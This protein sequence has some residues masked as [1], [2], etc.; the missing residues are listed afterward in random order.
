MEVVTQFYKYSDVVIDSDDGSVDD[1]QVLFELLDPERHTGWGVE[2]VP[3]SPHL[4]LTHRWIGD[5]RFLPINPEEKIVS[6]DHEEKYV[7]VAIESTSI[8]VYSYTVLMDCTSHPFTI[9][10]FVNS[11]ENTLFESMK[12]EIENE[13]DPLKKWTNKDGNP[14]RAKALATRLQALLHSIDLQVIRNSNRELLMRGSEVSR[15]TISR[16]ESPGSIRQ[17]TPT[18][19]RAS[20]AKPRQSKTAPTQQPKRQR[21]SGAPES[22][23]RKDKM[24]EKPNEPELSIASALT[25]IPKELKSGEVPDYTSATDI[26]EKYWSDCQDCYIFDKSVKKE[27]AISQLTPAPEDWTIRAFEQ[28]GMRHMMNYLI[29]MPDKT[30]KQTLCVMPA[31]ESD[32]VTKDDW[33][34]I[35]RGKFWIING[36]HSVA[37]SKEMLISNPPIPEQILKHF[38]TW[39]CYIIFTRDKEKLRKISAFYNRVNHFA[40]FMPSWSTN[41]LGARTIWINLGRPAVAAKPSST[42]TQLTKAEKCY[43]VRTPTLSSRILCSIQ[44]DSS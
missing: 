31:V 11:V 27:L 12:K 17:Q 16:S 43:N 25:Q 23:A 14:L 26:Y 36:Q 22:S 30:D 8:P 4:V 1:T 15:Q 3:L 18:V 34:E 37:A 21:R 39:N 28:K 13:E 9:E 19:G 10:P 35:K 41:I 32:V 33:D 5:H 42:R 6:V 44:L 24:A 29:E 7:V 20:R 38:R 2:L 40:N